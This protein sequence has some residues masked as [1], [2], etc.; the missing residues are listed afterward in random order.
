MKY[1]LLGHGEAEP[2]KGEIFVFSKRGHRLERDENHC[3]IT[4]KLTTTR[5]QDDMIPTFQKKKL[6]FNK[7]KSHAHTTPLRSH[8]GRI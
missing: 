5:E 1:L 2:W 3:P 4:C 8:R 7:G 6:R